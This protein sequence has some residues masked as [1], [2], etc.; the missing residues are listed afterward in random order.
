MSTTLSKAEKA[1][2]QSIVA[3]VKKTWTQTRV[4]IMSD[5]WKGMRERQLLNFFVNNLYD[6]IFL[7]SV[8]ASDAVKYA[9]LL[10]NILDLVV[11]EVGED[12]VIQVVMDNASNYKKVGEMLMKKM[13]RL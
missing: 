3:E 8:D 7:K 6:T 11:E 5:G 10:F 13:T 1:N 4:S 12:L 9:T 2:T